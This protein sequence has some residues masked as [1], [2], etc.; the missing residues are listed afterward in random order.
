MTFTLSISS[1]V[2]NSANIYPLGFS[3]GGRLCR[4]NNCLFWR[5][6]GWTLGQRS[7]IQCKREN[8]PL[9]VS[10]STNIY[11]LGLNSCNGGSLC[12]LN[13]CLIWRLDAFPN[14]RRDGCIACWWDG[15]TL[16]WWDRNYLHDCLI[17]KR[18]FRST[19]FPY[20]F[21][22]AKKTMKIII[23]RRPLCSFKL[24]L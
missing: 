5:R 9:C 15:C 19:Y 10:N 3:S 4:L 11:P 16:C 24:I 8:W 17:K 18:S 1:N 12:S 22:M 13:N 7:W 14:C 20:P 23:T 21:D 6:E 2:S